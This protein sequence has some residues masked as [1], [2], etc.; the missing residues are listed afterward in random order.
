LKSIILSGGGS[1][2]AGLKD[3]ICRETGL[4]VI[5]FNPFL[6]MTYDNKQFDEKYLTTVAPE[7]AIATGLAIR[8][9]SF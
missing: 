4:D 6:N 5:A 8:S 9:A 1:K 3:Y 2:V 7:M